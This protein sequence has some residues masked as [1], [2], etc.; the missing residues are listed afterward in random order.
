MSTMLETLRE[1]AFQV[2]DELGPHF[3]EA[4]YQNAFEVEC[5]MRQLRFIRQPTLNIMYKGNIVGFQRPDMIVEGQVVIEMKVCRETNTS[6]RIMKNWESQ[7]RNYL[8]S[9]TFCGLLIV[10]GS[11]HVEC[12]T[13]L[14]QGPSQI[15]I[16][17]TTT[18]EETGKPIQHENFIVSIP[19]S[20]T[21]I[22]E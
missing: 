9:T 16:V 20:K 21:P 8:K 13:L 7:L 10:F 17:T 12:Q 3:S 19:R 2:F 18:G 11:T 22:F 14:G 15:N 1:C 4:T 6:H 5:Q